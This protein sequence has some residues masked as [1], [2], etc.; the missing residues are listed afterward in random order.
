MSQCSDFK[1]SLW[2]DNKC[3]QIWPYSKWVY[4]YMYRTYVTYLCANVLIHCTLD[5]LW[6]PRSTK[7]YTN[8]STCSNILWPWEVLHYHWRSWGFWDRIDELVDRTWSHKNYPNLKIRNQIWIPIQKDKNVVRE[9]GQGQGY[10]TWRQQWA[11]NSRTAGRSHD[12]G[13]H[14]R[15]FPLSSCKIT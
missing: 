15:N 3:S 12:T 5:T 6:R 10:S 4:E 14:W 7:T 1:F 11:A 2:Y 8:T 13:I 9:R